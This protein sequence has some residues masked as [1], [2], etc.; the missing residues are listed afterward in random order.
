MEPI[1]ELF[2]GDNRD[3][4]LLGQSVEQV[5]GAAAG[6]EPVQARRSGQDAGGEGAEEVRVQEAGGGGEEGERLGLEEGR[7]GLEEDGSRG[8]GGGGGERGCRGEE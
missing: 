2:R 8:V 1:N 4:F 6:P 3:A 7:E 5:T